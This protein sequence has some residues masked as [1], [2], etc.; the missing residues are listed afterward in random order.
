[1]NQG[2]LNSIYLKDTDWI[3]NLHIIF[4]LWLDFAV[5]ITKCLLCDYNAVGAIFCIF[6]SLLQFVNYFLC[7]LLKILLFN[8]FSKFSWKLAW[9][10]RH[11]ALICCMLGWFWCIINHANQFNSSYLNQFIS[12]SNKI[13]TPS[14]LVTE[15]S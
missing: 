6:C 1:L 11:A 3:N 12:F 10:W 13:Y 8:T 14:P 5:F 4:D 15:Y 2:L 9:I 7:S